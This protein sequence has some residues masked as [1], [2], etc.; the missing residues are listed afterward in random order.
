MVEAQIRELVTAVQ[1]VQA[2]LRASETART[3]LQAQVERMGRASGERKIGVDKRNLG[4]PS[5][6]NG[7]QRLAGLVTSLSQLRGPGASGIE[8]RDAARAAAADSRNQC[9]SSRK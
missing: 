8:G 5:Q 2:Q 4:R 7:R 9:G 3:T 1:T 6:F